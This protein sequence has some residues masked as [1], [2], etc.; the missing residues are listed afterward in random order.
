MCL[1]M[2]TNNRLLIIKFYAVALLF[3]ALVVLNSAAFAE[4]ERI[5]PLTCSYDSYSWNVQ[6]KRAVA[7]RS[8]SHAYASLNANEVDSVSGCSVCREDQVRIEL[9][10][11]TPFEIC[12]SLAARVKSVL[13]DLIDN[14]VPI[15]EVIGYRVGK[16]RGDVDEHGNRTRFSNHSFGI[17]LDINPQHNGLYD[18][19]PQ[20][21][22]HCRLIRGGPWRP[23]INDASHAS[24]GPVVLALQALGLRWGGTIAGKQKDFMHF[25]ISGY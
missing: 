25:S 24:D 20:F 8:V 3:S 4:G 5:T 16:T 1:T 11:V 22:P 21:G 18:H 10:S 23:Y 14:G 2:R 17:A 15:H 12:H 7:R 9:P 19:C 6:Q 13:L